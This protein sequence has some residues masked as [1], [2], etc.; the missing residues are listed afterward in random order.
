MQVTCDDCQEV[1]TL[2]IQVAHLD[3]GIEKNFFT[4]P[5]CNH[6]YI[7]YCTDSNVRNKQNIMKSLWYKLRTTRNQKKRNQLTA[8]IN[9]LEVDIKEMMNDLKLIAIGK[10]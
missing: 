3:D 8:E 4:C 9:Q 1:Y 7:A 5:H 10:E 6:E 2:E